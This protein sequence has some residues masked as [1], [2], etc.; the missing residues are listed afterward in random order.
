VSAPLFPASPY[1]PF[2]QVVLN[3][4]LWDLLTDGNLPRLGKN[5]LI[6]A[7]STDL[8]SMHERAA[9]VIFETRST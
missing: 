1:F 3:Q 8:Y 2:D 5:A 6:Y 9:D 4:Q 7:Q